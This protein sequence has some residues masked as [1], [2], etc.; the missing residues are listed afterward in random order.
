[1]DAELSRFVEAVHDELIVLN[2]QAR[3]M[4]RRGVVVLLDGLEKLRGMSTNRRDVLNSAER[5]LVRGAPATTLPV[6]VVFTTP[7]ALALRLEGPVHFLPL[8]A[9]ADR[10]G[11]RHAPG[12]AA[13]MEIVRRQVPEEVLVEIFGEATWPEAVER[14]IGASAGSPRDLVRM[15]RD[16][17]AAQPLRE[18]V[19]RRILTEV[20][21]RHLSQV[22]E[23]A[24][25]LLARIH[26]AKALSPTAPEEHVILK[27]LLTDGVLVRYQQDG[28]AWVDVHPSVCRIPGV[29]AVGQGRWPRRDNPTWRRA[30]SI[31]GRARQPPPAPRA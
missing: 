23:R 6:Q 29:T 21:E 18:A 31:L 24:I 5:V 2:E 3:R 10:E 15:L 13:A 26:R 16:C 20:G 11:R 28:E 4:G 30:G 19:F 17:I 14:L 1:M 22:P 7:P 9:V 27:R 12:H 8:I 25:P